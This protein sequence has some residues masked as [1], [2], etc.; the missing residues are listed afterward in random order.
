[1]KHR[2]VLLIEPGDG[3]LQGYFP[4]LPG[5]T[6][7]GATKAELL[8]NAREALQIYL[9]DYVERGEPLP[10]GSDASEMAVLEIDEEDLEAS[11]LVM[12]AR[13]AN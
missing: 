12:P 1:M 13:K 11:S 7:A 9:E 3:Q 4:E 5:C 6:T 2:Y 10:G 8:A